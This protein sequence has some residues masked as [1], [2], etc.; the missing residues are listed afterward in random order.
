M[1]ELTADIKQ[2]S[3]FEIYVFEHKEEKIAK[4]KAF[5]EDLIAQCNGDKD[6]EG[7][8]PT[9]KRHNVNIGTFAGW[10]SD[11]DFLIL[12]ESYKLTRNSA[13]KDQLM[14][15]MFTGE[16]IGRAAY[17]QGV[18]NRLDS[19]FSE[20]INIVGTSNS[21]PVKTNFVHNDAERKG[22]SA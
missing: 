19:E 15:A 21:L 16:G 1:Q 2:P 11:P 8:L 3:P 7:I 13:L 17:I 14:K 10:Q 22:D 5:A 4:Q 20:K 12:F 18:L 6:F 9:L